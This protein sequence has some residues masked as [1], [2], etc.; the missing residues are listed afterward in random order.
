MYFNLLIKYG[1]A[2]GLILWAFEKSILVSSIN[3]ITRF[4]AIRDDGLTITKIYCNIEFILKNIQINSMRN[5]SLLVIIFKIF[6]LLQ[7]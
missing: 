4:G 2:I 3:F 6:F 7:Y 1:V 5:N